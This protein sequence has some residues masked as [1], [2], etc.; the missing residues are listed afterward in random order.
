[1]RPVQA[2]TKDQIQ[3]SQVPPVALVRYVLYYSNL[4]PS[5]TLHLGIY[6]RLLIGLQLPA[7]VTA[8][9]GQPSD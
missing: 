8:P 6:E 5:Q 3:L 1:M 2:L 4:R 7:P 9:Q